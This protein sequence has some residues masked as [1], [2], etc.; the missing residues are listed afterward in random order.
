MRPAKAP[1]TERPAPALSAGAEVIRRCAELARFT[2]QPG[3]LT[4]LYLTPEHR[5]AAGHVADW[6]RQAGMTV[7]IDAAATVVGRY[8]GT[9]P[10]AP[11][12]L[13][14]SHID[15]VRD[16]GRYDGNLGVV[17]AIQAVGALHAR[18]ER[19]PCA[20]EVL[21]FGDEEGVRFPV[22]LT[23]SRA[24]AGTL[25]PAMLDAVDEDGISLRAA[26]E[27]FGCDPGDL[28]A[29]ARN[30]LVPDGV[31]PD[32][33]RVLGYIELH[34]EQAPALEAEGLP[35]GIVTGIAGAT[36]FAAEVVGVAAHAG[37]MPMAARHDAV[38]AMAEMV[39]A[40]ER[41]ALATPGLVATVGRVEAVPGAVNVIASGA[42]FTIDLRSPDDAVRARALERLRRE[43]AGIATRR[44]VGLRMRE[45]Y[46]EPACVCAPH[47]VGA[48][49]E[50]VARA[51]LRPF[52]LPSGAGHDGL[53]LAPLCPIGM[54]FVRCEGGI[55]HSP[56]E[57]VTVA[58]AEVAGQV[59]LDFL[60]H[61]D[62]RG[63]I[64]P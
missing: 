36:R 60:H 61:F 58:D 59:L 24:L 48:L 33:R 21:A 3:A 43:L 6:M 14:G 56:E 18:G 63:G 28:P 27:R 34:I 9:T 57:E 15:T 47:L 37:A 11:A 2:S 41:L 17:L 5:A 29:L 12:L 62:P 16:A 53:A 19:L 49:A 23:G 45:T 64:A 39:L 8:E 1:T 26:L 30:A 31:S 32:R 13:L 38:T 50:S 54:L 10:D 35:V 40:V 55:S 42:R 51:G 4:R 7:A 22:T 25:D 52:L 20:I 44:A 46:D